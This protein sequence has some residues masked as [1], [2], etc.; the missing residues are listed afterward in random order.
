M[1]G[2]LN[3]KIWN[4][5]ADVPTSE[6]PSV[7]AVG[8]FDGVHIG[9]LAILRQLTTLAQARHESSVVVTFDRHPAALFAPESAPEDI[10]GLELRLE[11]L[12]GA[13]VDATLVLPFT[14]E[15]AS[16]SARDFVERVLVS[17]LRA[18]VV[19]VGNDFR[20]GANALGDIA[21]LRGLG[22]TFGFDVVTVEDVQDAHGNRASS[23]SIRGLMAVGNVS[24]AADLL[25]RLPSV[26][27]TVV[28]GAARGRELGFPTANLSQNATGLIPDDGVYAGWL[29]VEAIRYPAAIS[30]GT[31]PTFEGQQ[32]RTV[33]AYVI[34]EDLDL[35]DKHAVIEF[36]ER[37]RGMVSYDGIEPLILQMRDDV[38]QAR[39]ML[40]AHA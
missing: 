30:V 32:H 23:S 13:G 28:H 19:L 7:V 2:N 31:N 22:E 26:Q 29:T 3:M 15:L 16:L 24:A 1:T 21:M 25:G 12:A 39:Q 40:K 36:A 37:L 6:A 9:H 34:D 27:G 5:L 38:D 18:S 35:Y 10:T 4:S 11:L 33:E 14:R 8:K 20:F 17:A